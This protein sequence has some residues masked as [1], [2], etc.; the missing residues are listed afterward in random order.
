MSDVKKQ[1]D[2]EIKHF[3]PAEVLIPE[4]MSISDLK[5]LADARLYLVSDKDYDIFHRLPLSNQQKVD[6]IKTLA[7]TAPK[8]TI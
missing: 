8:E 2:S 5:I 1:E 7:F 3:D 6:L 4:P